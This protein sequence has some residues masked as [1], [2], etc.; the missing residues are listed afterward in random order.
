MQEGT[1]YW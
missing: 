1:Q